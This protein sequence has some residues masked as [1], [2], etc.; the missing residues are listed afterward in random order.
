MAGLLLRDGVMQQQQQQQQQQAGLPGQLMRPGGLHSLQ[1]HQ[2]QQA[3]SQAGV[4]S[5]RK[6]LAGGGGLLD[7]LRHSSTE[8]MHFTLGSWQQQHHAVLQPLQGG[9]GADW[10]SLAS[11]AAAVEF[12]SSSP[13][14]ISISPVPPGSAGGGSS[15]LGRGRTSSG[16]PH[17][18]A[19]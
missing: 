10:G 2:Q 15:P 3:L 9:V 13:V 7:S 14:V 16:I 11:Q 8:G 1:Q 17:G 18:Y 6:S 12:T 5:A 19:H 4:P